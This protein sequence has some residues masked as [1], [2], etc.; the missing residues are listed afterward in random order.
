MLKYQFNRPCGFFLRSRHLIMQI[1]S[2][3]KNLASFPLPGQRIAVV[4]VTSSGKTTL[5]KLLSYRLMI[6][7]VEMDGIN[8]QPGWQP[9]PGDQFR[10]QVS[11]ALSGPA[12]VVDGNYSEVRD[13]VWGRA[14]T[15]VWLDYPL[16]CSFWRLLA[17]SLRR[18]ISQ[19]LLWNGNKETLRGLFFS[20]DSLFL[21][22]FK[23]YRRLRAVYP[24]VLSDPAYAHLRVVRLRHPRQ[25]DA[26]LA[27]IR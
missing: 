21:Y 11:A 8:W 20:R 3:E 2:P 13:I 7:H 12:W 27:A 16:W 1:N 19:E 22:I 14:D 6:P 18:L 24:R 17:R 23:S 10:S 25:T 5:A 15:L 9:L 4:G 26:W